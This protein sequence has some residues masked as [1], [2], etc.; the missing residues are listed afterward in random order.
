MKL[1]NPFFKVSS[2]E[3]T[4]RIFLMSLFLICLTQTAYVTDLFETKPLVLTTKLK[5][6]NDCRENMQMNSVDAYHDVSVGRLAFDKRNMRND[7]L[8]FA[9]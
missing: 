2:Y 6:D 5:P 3:V 7:K 8:I 9:K 1:E 4:N